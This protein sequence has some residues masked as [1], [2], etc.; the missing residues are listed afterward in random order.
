[1]ELDG[2]ITVFRW[3]G[4]AILQKECIVPFEALE[5][6]VDVPHKIGTDRAEGITLFST[7]KSVPSSL[8]VVYDSASES[9]QLKESTMVADIIQLPKTSKSKKTK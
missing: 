6:V 7:D 5:H 8:L 1:M 9:R 4:G 3:K 2:T